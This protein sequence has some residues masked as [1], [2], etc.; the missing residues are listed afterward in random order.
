MLVKGKSIMSTFKQLLKKIF[1]RFS[2]VVSHPK[3]PPNTYWKDLISND[4]EYWQKQKQSATG[5]RI[6]IA[7]SMGG[8]NHGA[9]VE[10]TLAVALTL[11]GAKVDILLCDKALSACQLIKMPYKP[12]DFL[13]STEMARC[14]SCHQSGKDLFEPLGLPIHWYNSFLSQHENQEALNT[15]RRIA[16]TTIDKA[17]TA[18]G[19]AIGEHANAGALRYYGRGDFANEPESEG[20]RRRYFQAGQQTTYILNNLFAQEHYDVVVLNHGLYVPQGIIVE[21]CKRKNIRIV[22]WNPAYKKHTF[23]FSHDDTYHHTMISEDPNQWNS[24]ELIPAMDKELQDYLNSRRYGTEDWI[25]FHDKPTE[26]FDRIA[27]NLKLDRDKP[28]VTLLSNVMWDAQLHYKS[29]AFPSMLDW[30]KQTISYFSKRADLQLII[31]VHP[32]EI[33]GLMPSRQLLADEI[34]RE[35]PT[36][37]NNVF[38]V[39]PDDQTS[40]YALGEHSDAVLIYNTKTGIELAAMG[41]PVIVAGEAWIRNKQFSHDATSKDEYFEILDQMPFRSGLSSEKTRLA[42]KYAYHFFMRRMIPLPFIHHKPG[43]KFELSL[44]SLKDLQ[45]GQSSGLDTICNGILHRT[46]FVYDYENQSQSKAA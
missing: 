21:A 2:N 19:M 22:T 41:I 25:W 39:P 28:I 27:A 33:R 43:P 36:L 13:A 14:Q 3:N 45:Q 20:V 37:P 44:S 18:D 32:A 5:P 38:V 1:H 40:T 4:R 46:P 12:K 15:S 30:V 34:F 29:N 8:F 42:R 24:L 6:L 26:D 11:R 31:R 9:I 7:T 16:L 23:V 35:F 17:Q 10:S